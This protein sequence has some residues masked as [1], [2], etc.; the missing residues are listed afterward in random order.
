MSDSEP[1]PQVSLTADRWTL[2]SP[3]SAYA[4]DVLAMFNDPEV[5]R[6][7]PAENV[8]DSESAA[9]WLERSAAWEAR[10][11]VWIILD[12]N[13]RFVGTSLLWDMDRSG[14]LH[15]SVGYRIAPWARRQGVAT[16]AV[17]AMATFAFDEVGLARLDLVHTVANVGSCLVAQG[18]GFTLEGTLRS[19]YR[20]L[21]GDRWDCHIHGLLATDPR[22]AW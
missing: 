13:G 18:A 3:R 12:A 10:W 4:A 22:N 2:V 20:T 17:R 8:V 5:Q 16:A 19:E 15:G 7:H 1:L 21:D 9:G 14:Q 11:A 6:W